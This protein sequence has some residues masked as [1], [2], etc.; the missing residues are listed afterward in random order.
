MSS[1]TVF[2]ISGIPASSFALFQH[3]QTPPVLGLRTNKVV[4]RQREAVSNRADDLG[5]KLI[6]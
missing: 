6:A 1:E 4:L 2:E 3:V 5:S